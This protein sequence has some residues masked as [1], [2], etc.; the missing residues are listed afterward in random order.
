MAGKAKE[1]AGFTTPDKYTV[2]IH[3][4]KP[5]MAFMGAMAMS[6]TDVVAKEWVD[7]WRRSTATRSAPARSCSTT[8]RGAARS[9]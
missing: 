5:D 6:F 3:L 2:V 8:G 9:S 7:K 4:S 1:I